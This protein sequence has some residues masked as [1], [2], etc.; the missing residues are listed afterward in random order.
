VGKYETF[1]Q[2]HSVGTLKQ[3]I[4]CYDYELSHEMCQ[5]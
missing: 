2:T 5:V 4:Q 3:C 1:T